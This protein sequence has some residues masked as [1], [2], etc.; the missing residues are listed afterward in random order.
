MTVAATE[1]MFGVGRTRLSA[2]ECRRRDRICVAEGGYGFTQIHEPTGEWRSWFSAPNRGEPWNRELEARV[3][4][5]VLLEPS[6]PAGYWISNIAGGDRRRFSA[7]LDGRPSD[8]S[9]R[10]VRALVRRYGTCGWA[11]SDTA[12]AEAIT[13]NMD[14]ADTDTD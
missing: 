9:I 1:Y 6:A 7:L 13:A 2:R 12:I 3:L 11:C 5:R 4:A 10:Y 14:D 8:A